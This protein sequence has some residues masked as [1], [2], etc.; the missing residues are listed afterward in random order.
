MRCRNKGRQCGGAAISWKLKK[1]IKA[2]LD[3][4]TGTIFKDR[5]ARVRVCLVYPNVY[6][7]GMSNL[8]FQSAHHLFNS[9]DDC[10]CERAF[11]PD[12]E[13]ISEYQRTET[14]LFSYESFTPLKDF[15]VVAFSL[16]F[17][18]DYVN[19]P[20]ILALAGI[21]VNAAEREDGKPFVMAGG[22]AV[23]LN[24][25]PIGE[26]MDLFLVGE[27]EGAVGKFIEGFAEAGEKRLDKDDTLTALDSVQSV[28]VPSLYEL[29]YDGVKITGRAGKDKAKPK[30]LASKNLSLEGLPIPRSF[31][32]TP[33]AEFNGAFLAEIERGCGRGCRFCAAGFLYLPPRF[34][35]LDEVKEI[36]KDG[37][38]TTGKAGLV[39]A[40]VSEYPDLKTLLAFGTEFGCEMTLSSLRADVLDSSLATALKDA[41]Y[42]TLTI[43]PEAGS[44][45]LRRV[46]NKNISDEQILQAARLAGEAGFNKIKLYFLIGLPTET[47][48]DVEAIADIS[49]E[50]RD[51]LN[52]GTI[53]LSINPFIPKPVTP[54]QW[55]AFEEMESLEKKVLIIKK[56]LQNTRGVSMKAMSPKESLF[57]AYLARADRRA[58]E[59]IREASDKGV[60]QALKKHSAFIKDSA[61]RNREKDEVLPWDSI[62]HGV[63]KTYLWKEYNKGIEALETSPCEVGECFRCGVCLPDARIQ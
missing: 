28:Y 43:A 1:K 17:E 2:V 59:I 5:G 14:P 12:A 25:E 7:L 39:G 57:Q 47:D 53:S 6:R 36:I 16:P 40:A 31:I 22:A 50:I 3:R 55:A 45:R 60:K 35:G 18:D 61:Y 13:D 51:I 21:P 42:K 10:V 9:L 34:R 41:G 46:I 29:E 49:K 62:D 19:I 15:D 37:V 11:L 38:K 4:E 63:R 32:T 44:E 23:S 56:R 33:D 26:F 48:A 30:V 54:F 24:P 52:K 8:G 58:G 20:K 27:G